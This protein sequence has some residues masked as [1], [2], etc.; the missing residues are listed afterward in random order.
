MQTPAALSFDFVLK[1]KVEK[2]DDAKSRMLLEKLEED[3]VKEKAKQETLSWVQKQEDCKKEFT[4]HM[5][6]VQVVLSL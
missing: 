2:A 6:V 3:K 4:Q 1:N 5:S